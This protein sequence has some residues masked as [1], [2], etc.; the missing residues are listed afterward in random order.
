M[1]GKRKSGVFFADSLGFKVSFFGNFTMV[2][3]TWSN[4]HI[5]TYKLQFLWR[6]WTLPVQ[7]RE[8]L[9]A[10]SSCWR[11]IPPGGVTFTKIVHGRACRTSKIWLSLYQFFC[12]ISHPSVYHFQKKSTQFW[13]NWVFF[14]SNLLK[15]QPIYVIWAPSSLMK[16]PRS[17]Y[18]ISRKSAPKG[19]HIYM[20]IWDPPPGWSVMKNRI[21]F[22][23]ESTLPESSSEALFQSKIISMILGFACNLA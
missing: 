13:P 9:P 8:L 10:V 19:R 1:Y 23:W 5:V 3:R 12:Q 21:E 4:H 16:T 18:Q 14:Y 15:I 22:Q 2:E 7:G 20:S 11:V 17:L 6:V